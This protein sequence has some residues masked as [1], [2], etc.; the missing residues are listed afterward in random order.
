[1][2]LGIRQSKCE[3][4][5]NQFSNFFQRPDVI[6]DSARTEC[7]PANTAARD[8]ASVKSNSRKRQAA[9]GNVG[10]VLFFNTGAD[11]IIMLLL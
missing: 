4:V 2:T 3:F 1:M 6:A 8:P 5:I 9:F 11:K 10:C 7:G